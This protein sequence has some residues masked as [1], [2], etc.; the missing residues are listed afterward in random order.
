MS[1]LDETVEFV[2][3]VFSL[4]GEQI[5]PDYAARL[6]EQIRARLDWL[7]D[8][9][10]AGIH[11]LGGVSPTPGC[12]YLTQRARLTLRLPRHRIEAAGALSGLRLDLGGAVEIGAVKSV[13]SLEPA[14]VLY[15]KFVTFALPGVEDEAVFLAECGR[16]FEAMGIQPR[17]LCGKPRRLATPAGELR[18]FSLLLDRV[19]AADSL[20]MQREGLGEERKRGCGLF[21]PHK[22]TNAVG[23]D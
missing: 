1:A 10:G 15:S 4:R 21:V 6:L 16:R 5:D 9:A 20:R 23:G 13:R 22:S 2:D 7:D 12:L 14:K 3:A 11:P 19:G 17:L 18:G 8:E